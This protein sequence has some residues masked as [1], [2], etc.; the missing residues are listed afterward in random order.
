[1]EKL[2]FSFVIPA[3][4][5]ENYIENT[6]EHLQQLDYPADKFEVIVIENGSTDRTL[7]IAKK[8]ER[9][10]FRVLLSGKG[11]SR[12]RNVGIDHLAPQ[13]DW[14]VFLDADTTLEIEF[15]NELNT[16]LSQRTGCT[17]GT[18]SLR[19]VPESAY[20]RAWF[21]VHNVGHMLSR[22]SF[23]IHMV[24]RS[25]FPPLRYDE[26]MITAEDIHMI[27]QAE[28]QGTFFYMWT[29]SAATSTRRF[30]KLGWWYILFYWTFVAVLPENWQR[31]F[32]YEEVR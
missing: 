18:V 7:E 20:A 12:A 27:R 8:F 4:N 30:E 19:P 29:N 23:T 32:T 16:Y 24:K 13:S 1:M 14:V 26:H 21:W 15:L 3:H 17:T 11:V 28:R 25:L 22:T 31:H 5:E 6:L 2:F 9:V 10:G